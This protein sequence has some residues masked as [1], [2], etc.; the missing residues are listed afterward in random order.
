MRN[1][2]MKG[3]LSAHSNEQHVEV[4]CVQSITAGHRVRTLIKSGNTT[5]TKKGVTEEMVA[6]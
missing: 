2:M 4:W 5:M 3:G 1:K 6:D